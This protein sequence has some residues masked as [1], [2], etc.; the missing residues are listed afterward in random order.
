MSMVYTAVAISVVS[1]AMT[2]YSAY[3]SGESAKENAKVNKQIAD[4]NAEMQR[5]AADQE[6]EKATIQAQEKSEQTR[7]FI[8]RQSAAAAAS[9]IRIDTGSILDIFGES[10]ASG[11]LDE[12]RIIDNAQRQAAGL[13]QSADFELF[14]GES[15]IFKG[16]AA[17]NAG[18]MNAAGSILGQVGSLAKFGA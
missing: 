18:Y 15:E 12:L 6:R 8:S 7:R 9:G 16:N 2:A 13:E 17:A 3:A 10:A 1:M 4:N 11:K 14:K 5:R